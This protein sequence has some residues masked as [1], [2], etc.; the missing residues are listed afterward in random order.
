VKNL[1][2][3][4][5]RNPPRNTSKNPPRN[6][7]DSQPNPIPIQ[8][9]D[10]EQIKARNE[11]LE[12]EAGNL[13]AEIA[14]LKAQADAAREA[15]SDEIKKLRGENETLS[16]TLLNAQNDAENSKR[17]ILRLAEEIA[18]IGQIKARNEALEREAG[19]LSAEIVS[20]KAQAD[21]AREAMSDEIKK[22]RGENETLSQTLQNAQNEAEDSRREILRLEEENGGTGQIKARNAELERSVSE[23]SE[24]AGT[25]SAQLSEREDVIAEK[26]VKIAALSDIEDKYKKTAKALESIKGEILT[27]VIGGYAGAAKIITVTGSGGA[28]TSSVAA[29]LASALR[30]KEA[31]FSSAASSREKTLSAVLCADFDTVNPELDKWFSLNPVSQQFQG[32]SLPEREK[33]AFGVFL[34]QGLAAFSENLEPLIKRGGKISADFFGGLYFQAKSAELLNADFTGLF[35]LLGGVYEYIIVDLGRLGASFAKDSLIMSVQSIA[36]KNVVITRNTAIDARNT[37]LKLDGLNPPNPRR[38]LTNTANRPPK[39]S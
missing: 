5:P 13:S 9:I 34:K 12:R 33:T 36:H 25:L 7:T 37:R 6:P 28:G 14:T 10:I 21:A 18:D 8:S 4:L 20:L 32:G 17:E 16:E 29:S 11:A 1:P 26:D 35:N 19:D 31:A 27:S 3:N 2:R 30:G 39:S 15:M 38:S 22:L 24:T 23:L